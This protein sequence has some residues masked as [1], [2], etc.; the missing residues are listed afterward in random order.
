MML[1][2]SKPSRQTMR[3]GWPSAPVRYVHSRSTA[4]TPSVDVFEFITASRKENLSRRTVNASVHVG[5]A[6][7]LRRLT[8]LSG[9][10]EFPHLC[11]GPASGP[12]FKFV[13][14]LGCGTSLPPSG[15]GAGRAAEEGKVNDSRLLRGEGEHPNS[16]CLG[17][18]AQ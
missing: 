7:S 3:F 10:L 6:V 9:S 12:S 11:A 16:L 13:A 18:V 5:S 17:K 2:D 8:C 4:Y 15:S 1:K 14:T